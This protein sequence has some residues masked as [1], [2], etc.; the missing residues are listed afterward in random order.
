MHCDTDYIEREGR[1]GGSL[2]PSP[3]F[4][5]GHRSGMI[6]KT[7][8]P[9]RQESNV[10]R[11]ERYDLS[12]RRSGSQPPPTTPQRTRPVTSLPIADAW[13]LVRK[14]REHPDNPTHERI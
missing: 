7:L 10:L 13:W 6:E 9:G 5:P 12:F 4:P 3:L 11:F 8:R 1:R 2:A 14:G